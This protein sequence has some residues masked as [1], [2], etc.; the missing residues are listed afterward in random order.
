M[1]PQLADAV[2]AL[3]AGEVI[4]Y[5]T[6]TVYGLG[7]RPDAGE[8]LDALGLLK[9]RDAS[10]GLILI[11][12]EESQLRPWVDLPAAQ[13]AELARGWPAPLTWVVPATE[14]VGDAVTGGRDT[15]AVRI[16]DHALS[17]ALCRA[18]GSA[19]VS[20]SANRSGEPPL[21]DAS[22]VRAAFGDALVVVV[23]GACGGGA[24]SEI[25]DFATG[26]VLRAR[27]DADGGSA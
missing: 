20:T 16:P 24:P 8:A 5:P 14:A 9:Q 26:A 27:S 12:A 6:D 15:V 21:R 19:L 17:R 11:A 22:A 18:A 13:L 7:C 1:D 3:D 23:D 4:A 2:A 25:R 10:K